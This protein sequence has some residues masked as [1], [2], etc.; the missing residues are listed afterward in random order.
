MAV[1]IVSDVKRF[2]AF[3]P[4]LD[5]PR[6][7]AEEQVGVETIGSVGT[8]AFHNVLSHCSQEACSLDESP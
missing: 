6:I 3:N 8:S 1:Q 2:K 7:T 4:L 5:P